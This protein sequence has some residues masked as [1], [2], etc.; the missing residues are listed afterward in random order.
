MTSCHQGSPKRPAFDSFK[1]LDFQ[2]NN[3]IEL[4]DFKIKN[5]TA[6]LEGKLVLEANFEFNQ[7]L[8]QELGWEFSIEW[9]LSF[10]NSNDTIKL[11]IPHNKTFN[12]HTYDTY[13]QPFDD[14]DTESDTYYGKFT[15]PYIDCKL[16]KGKYQGIFDIV[17]R[18]TKNNKAVWVLKGS[19]DFLMPQLYFIKTHLLEMDIDV[20]DDLLDLA[21]DRNDMY[22]QI[23]RSG[24]NQI[25][26][27]SV[28]YKNSQIDTQNKEQ[29]STPFYCTAH[30]YLS[31]EFYDEDKDRALYRN[32]DDLLKSYSFRLDGLE[33]DTVDF[34]LAKIS[35][36]HQPIEI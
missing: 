12:A 2:E 15:L 32:K 25:L 18:S 8:L 22:W 23:R 35:I 21:F 11:E 29:I 3:A 34:E 7:K 10:I 4:S 30:E 19:F 27:Q 1:I 6:S 16:A 13:H 14:F 17:I 36:L 28:T 26:Y 5:D 31:L 24:N 33:K 20:A 9:H